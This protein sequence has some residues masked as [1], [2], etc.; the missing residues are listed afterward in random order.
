MLN[1]HQEKIWI[2]RVW[3]YS[4]FLIVLVF[5]G[6]EAVVEL[7]GG[8]TFFPLIMPSHL[9]TILGFITTFSITMTGFI[10]AIGAY[11]LAVSR[12]PA[13]SE[14]REEG[15]LSVFFHLY[16]AAI[17]FLLLTFGLCI[18]MALDNMTITWLKFILSSVILNLVH[19]IMITFIVVNQAR[20]S[21]DE[22]EEEY[23]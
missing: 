8:K 18:L 1:D 13:F 14:W 10:A 6:Y 19:I 9:P 11:L 2:G 3:F 12:S 17:V 5:G 15:Y 7:T 22:E 20:L 23:S 16:G 4:L 21:E